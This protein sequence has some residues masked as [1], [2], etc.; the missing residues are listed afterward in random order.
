MEEISYCIYGVVL[1]EQHN[2][3]LDFFSLLN[4]SWNY[5]LKVKEIIKETDRK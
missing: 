5:F 3:D 1:L 4:E 2:Y